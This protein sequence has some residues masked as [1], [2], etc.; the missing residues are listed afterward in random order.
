MTPYS[1][2]AFVL[3]PLL[4]VMLAACASSTPTPTLIPTPSPAPTPTEAPTPTFIPPRDPFSDTG[5]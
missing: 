4:A 2:L 3:G 1:R 5:A